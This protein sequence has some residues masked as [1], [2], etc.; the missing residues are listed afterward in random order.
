[1]AAER[2]S[3]HRFGNEVRVREQTREAWMIPWLEAMGQDLRFAGRSLRRAPGFAAAVM[4]VL[5]LGMGSNS[6][7]FSL[8]YAVF[9]QPLPYPNAGQIVVIDQRS[10][11]FPRA[12]AN[13]TLDVSVA[14]KE[15]SGLR[16]W[17]MYRIDVATLT[18]AGTPA[19]L[20]G[21]YI[22][23]S[24]LRALG[25]K[26]VAGRLL[27]PSDEEPGAAP[28]VMISARLWRARW[29]AS[30]AVIGRSI[31]L[32]GKNCN[33]VGVIPNWFR[34][35]TPQR[36]PL[37]WSTAYWQAWQSGTE[38]PGNR[39][40]QAVARLAPGMSLD[41]VQRQ[42]D[43][44]MQQL[45]HKYEQDRGWTFTLTPLREKMTA[46][47]AT[48]LWM[49][50]A[51]VGLVLLIA[52]ANAACLLSARSQ[53]R[54][55]EL[56]T[57]AALG[58]SRGRIAR[59]LWTETAVLIALGAG[60]GLALAAGGIAWLR[61]AAPADMPRLAHVVMNG[62]VVGFTAA[63]AVLVMLAFGLAPA[64]SAS[65]QR[66]H[67]SLQSARMAAAPRRGRGSAAWVVAQVALSLLLLVIAGLLLSAFARMRSVPLGFNPDH[68]LGL[69]LMVPGSRYATHAEQ[70]Q[71]LQRAQQQIAALPGTKSAAMVAFPPLQGQVT[72]FY[73]LP[74]KP[75]QPNDASQSIGYNEI[76]SRY[77]STMQI[78]LLRGRGIAAADE[79]MGAPVVVINQAAANALFAGRD[80]IGQRIRLTFGQQPWRTIVGVVGNVRHTLGN[81]PAAAPATVYV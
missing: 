44:V 1:M 19:M 62:P 47:V 13:S 71:F 58:A 38:N 33:V 6:A 70:W 42:L 24:A 41:Q 16:N 17:G 11:K 3:N 81:A 4:M 80:P 8:A 75:L 18:G 69:T 56:A 52:A 2:G 66:L 77:L 35:P 23:A 64:W 73:S 29:H 40:A 74:G 10:P 48:A 78:P 57:R 51:V 67:S 68:V 15:V 61:A 20:D 53:R 21:V 27:L 76:G 59:Q 31:Q 5:A 14:R 55:H 32:N 37:A 36:A 63:T 28:A 72:S 50:L 46:P 30:P 39:D 54:M 25:V 45:G 43:A 12:N 26:P 60:A 7:I 34:F 22:E 65:G 79:A 49:M 9:W